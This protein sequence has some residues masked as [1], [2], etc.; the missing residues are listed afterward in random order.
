M[1][2]N[3]SISIG[4]RIQMRRKKFQMSME[5]LA[6]IMGV[7]QAQISRYETGERHISADQLFHISV[8]LRTPIEWFYI[9]CRLIDIVPKKSPIKDENDL[10]VL[11]L[12]SKRNKRNK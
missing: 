1:S 3:I 6:E 5:T 11:D 10:L 9:D 7:S 8:I 12:V 4:H 2:N